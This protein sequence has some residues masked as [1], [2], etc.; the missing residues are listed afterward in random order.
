MK[1]QTVLMKQAV[2][3]LQA[4]E[5]GTIRKKLAQFDMKQHEFRETFRKTA[6][7]DFNSQDVYDRIDIVSGSNQLCTMLN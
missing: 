3:P 4:A 7:F 2:A 6:P 1:K 5:V